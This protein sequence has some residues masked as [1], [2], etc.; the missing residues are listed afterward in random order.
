VTAETVSTAVPSL[1]SV[2]DWEP[3]VP[4][5]CEPK[6]TTLGVGVSGCGPVWAAGGVMVIPLTAWTSV[7][8]PVEPVKPTYALDGITP[9]AGT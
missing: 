8:A 3:V 2:T 4:R 6:A 7:L 9:A 5:V 1:T